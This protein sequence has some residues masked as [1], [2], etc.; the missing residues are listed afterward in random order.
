M[1]RR[2][3][4]LDDEDVVAALARASAAKTMDEYTQATADLGKVIH[5]RAYGPGFFAAG[6]VFFLGKDVPDWGLDQSTG[7]GPLNLA[8]LVTRR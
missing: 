5:D 1:D 4:G 6:S 2:T 3:R 7:R 8:A